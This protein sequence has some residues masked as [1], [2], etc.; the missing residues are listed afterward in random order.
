MP[1]IVTQARIERTAEILRHED[2]LFLTI[3]RTRPYTTTEDFIKGSN[4]VTKRWL[5]SKNRA[6]L[7]PVQVKR[8]GPLLARL[9]EAFC[10]A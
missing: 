3:L 7:R 4:R 10:E 9:V 6:G 2:P 1:R 5:Q 8:P